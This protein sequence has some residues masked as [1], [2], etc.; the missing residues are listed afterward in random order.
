MKM[1]IAVFVACA[2]TLALAQADIARASYGAAPEFRAGTNDNVPGHVIRREGWT[3][4]AQGRGCGHGPGNECRR[5]Q[6]PPAQ[7]SDPGWCESHF[8]VDKMGVRRHRCPPVW[9]MKEKR[10]K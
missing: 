7:V 6:Y 1:L 10:K 8:V 2:I 3:R 4:I 5:D 9:N